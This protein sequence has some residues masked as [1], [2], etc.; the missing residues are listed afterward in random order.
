MDIRDLAQYTEFASA[1]W[2]TLFSVLDTIISSECHVVVSTKSIGDVATQYLGR[3]K[4]AVVGRVSNDILQKLAWLS[5]GI[6]QTKI[7]KQSA[8][9][10]CSSYQTEIQ[11]GQRYHHFVPFG[12]IKCQTLITCAPSQFIAEE[13]DRA[14][15]DCIGLLRQLK[16]SANS[17]LLHG[18]GAFEMDLTH[19]LRHQIES[20]DVHPQV[21]Q[22]FA[23]SIEALP[24]LLL[25]NSGCDAGK[26]LSILREARHRNWPCSLGVDGSGLGAADME[27]R[28]V[29]ELA[30]VRVKALRRATEAA[31]LV[32]SIDDVIL[33]PLEATPE[34][35]SALLDRKARERN[36]DARKKKATIA[37][38]R[39]L[40]H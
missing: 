39:G 38:E 11:G 1:E 18:G 26:H 23:D 32:I 28:G 17:R 35:R 36:V 15:D 10:R 40:I 7:F 14:L 3:N 20:S 29:C 8:F 25:K 9:G 19:H 34:E 22:A 31:C 37:Q 30:P 33:F 21:A 5:N 13:V 12:Q 24:I 6:P 4:I 2:D 16:G 27:K